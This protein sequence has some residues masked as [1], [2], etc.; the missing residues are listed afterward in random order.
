M[1]SESPQLLSAVPAPAS[2]CQFQ[3]CQ[4]EAQAQ[5]GMGPVHGHTVTPG[6]RLPLPG[7]PLEPTDLSQVESVGSSGVEPMFPPNPLGRVGGGLV[8]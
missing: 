8:Y 4:E 3:C 7:R 5:R 1:A 2:P 6:L